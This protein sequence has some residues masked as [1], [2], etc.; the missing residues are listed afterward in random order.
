MKKFRSYYLLPF[1]GL[2]SIAI[3]GW[4]QNQDTLNAP[5]IL[6]LV[7]IGLIL[8]LI[9]GYLRDWI[10]H[11]WLPK[12]RKEAYEKPPFT[13]L[14]EM[15]FENKDNVYLEG[16]YE[17]YSVFIIYDRRL[18]IAVS[19]IFFYLPEKLDE[20]HYNEFLK[21]IA[22]TKFEMSVLGNLLTKVEF[23]FKIGEVEAIEKR[24]KAGVA[25]LKENHYKPIAPL[26][27]KKLYEK[28]GRI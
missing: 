26:E 24:L 17:D 18:T 16:V 28:K 25:F 3:F 5:F 23:G 11:E 4:Y 14:V 6:F 10:D 15:G 27:L 19:L 20:K 2:G 22:R 21:Q 8:P 7:F 13:A 12:K 1:L 9:I